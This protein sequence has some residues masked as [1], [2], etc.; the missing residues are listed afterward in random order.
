MPLCWGDSRHDLLRSSHPLR[1]PVCSPHPGA[2]IGIVTD[3][4]SPF[5]LRATQGTKNC[6]TPTQPDQ[7]LLVRDSC[8]CRKMRMT[9]QDEPADPHAACGEVP[10]A[11]PQ[12]A[13]GDHGLLHAP[14]PVDAHSKSKW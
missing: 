8:I 10:S 6:R 1:R 14:R 2:G 4:C 3:R 7:G 11:S 5:P 12:N 9:W 13:A